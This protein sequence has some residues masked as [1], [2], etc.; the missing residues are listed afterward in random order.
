MLP[1][2]RGPRSSSLEPVYAEACER[3]PGVA[4]SFDTFAAR[5]PDP[6]P[7]KFHGTDFFL[8]CA[9]A[10]GLA[11][12]V[13]I[14]DESLIAPLAD[15]LARRRFSVTA[16]DE[17]LQRL[18]IKL[19]TGATPAIAEYGGRG[20]LAGWLKVCAVRTA[21]NLARET[22]REVELG[23]DVLGG[24]SPV[25]GDPHLEGLR[26]WSRTDL[27]GVLGEA[28]RALDRRQRNLLRQYHLDRARIGELAALH[29][30]H[31]VT[32]SIWLRAAEEALATE[33]RRL[34]GTRIGLPADEIETL[35][36]LVRSKIDL[37][38]RTMMATGPRAEA[39][40]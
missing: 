11:R 5:A 39:P 33:V 12:A 28:F 4:L 6:L 32:L 2:A 31:R 7:A 29:R 25:G 19:F 21:L 10:N 17:A 36:G 34:L 9:A 38:L 30:V 22:A 23:E 26:V 24:L 13:M 20:S 16:A 40:A 15:E 1:A 3:Y 8:A 35:V 27:D 14:I 18:R 37:S